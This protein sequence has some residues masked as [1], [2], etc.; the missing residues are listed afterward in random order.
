MSLIKQIKLENNLYDIGAKWSNIDKENIIYGPS[1]IINFEDNK[2]E[3]LKKCIINIK[4]V[5]E[6]SGDSSPENV[7][8]IS[9]WTGT[10][11]SH[12]GGNLVPDSWY[13]TSLSSSGVTGAKEGDSFVLNGVNTSSDGIN[14]Y[15]KRYDTVSEFSLPAGTYTLSGISGPPADN[16][17]ILALYKRAN[18]SNVQL[19]Y[20]QQRAG[21]TS[22]TV[23]LTEYTE[24]LFLVIAV[25][26]GSDVTGYTIKPMLEP[27]EDAS[28]F[29][30]YGNWNEINASFPSAAGTVYGGTLDVLTGVLTV[31]HGK[32]IYDG[33]ETWTSLGEGY[34]RALSSMKL[35]FN[36]STSLCDK[37]P[38][39][40]S[41]SIPGIQLGYANNSTPSVYIRQAEALIGV[42]TADELKSWLAANPVEVVYPL[43]ELITYQLTP[44]IITSLIGQNN[45]WVDCGDISIELENFYSDIQ[46]EITTN[47]NENTL[48]YN[49]NYSLTISNH[50]ITNDKISI[51]SLD[52]YD[53][54]N[55]YINGSTL[56]NHH[57]ILQKSDNITWSTNGSD[58]EP[59]FIMKGAN[60]KRFKFKFSNS[61]TNVDIG[62]D[63]T[64]MDGSGAFFRNSDA[65]SNPG[66][67]GFFARKPNTT[68]STTADCTE[69]YGYPNGLLYWKKTTGDSN[70]R[71]AINATSSSYTL[72]VNGTTYLKGDT[73]ISANTSTVGCTLQYDNTLNTLNFV[74]D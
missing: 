43:A 26:A 47:L 3:P 1:E 54:Y 50:Y 27:G 25:R 22:R 72:Y 59:A 63:W 33:S 38:F 69:L 35:G 62:W 10:K 57:I 4:A 5:Q 11:L 74:F 14:W 48:L 44:E 12:C 67:F 52:H 53:N 29:S 51:N 73:K 56:T 40:S 70:P 17:P 66:G 2:I 21:F 37:F 7:R 58:N 65:T 32:I 34:Y 71:F 55:L 16:A 61:G 42:T 8:S 15:I 60:D 41:A 45:I 9:G 23:T 6:G 28:E 31:T 24:H 36:N 46:N 18:D 68:T 13:S 64:L 30:P 19:V 39:T 20:C 49:K